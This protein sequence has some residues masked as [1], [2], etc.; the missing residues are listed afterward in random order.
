METVDIVGS[1]VC[2]VADIFSN[3]LSRHPLG[4]LTQTA[5][6]VPSESKSE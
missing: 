6:A 1:A 5:S 4:G 2:L 3:N